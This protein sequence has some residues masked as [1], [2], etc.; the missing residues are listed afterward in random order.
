MGQIRTLSTQRIG[1]RIARSPPEEIAAVI[2]GLN[3][4]LGG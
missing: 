2:E 4:I 1:K 3:E